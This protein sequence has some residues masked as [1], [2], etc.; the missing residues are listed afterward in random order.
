MDLN[1]YLTSYIKIKSKWIK[2]L[3]KRLKQY[4]FWEKNLVTLDDGKFLNKGIK[5]N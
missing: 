5:M 1:S 2:N 4:K 3:N